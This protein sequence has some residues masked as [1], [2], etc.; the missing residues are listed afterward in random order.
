MASIREGGPIPTP[1]DG[2]SDICSL[3]R[4]LYEALGGT[5]QGRGTAGCCAVPLEQL[6]PE[7]STGLSDI[8]PTSA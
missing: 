5:I 3:G 6:N 4:F 2:R 1:V 8:D 7:V